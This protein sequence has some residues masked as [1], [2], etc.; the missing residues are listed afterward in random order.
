MVTT[1][2]P[3]KLFDIFMKIMAIILIMLK[4]N[5][6]S[7]HNIKISNGLKV[8]LVKAKCIICIHARQYTK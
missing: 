8:H 2:C 7:I 5:V 4:F 1:D 6:N 3:R